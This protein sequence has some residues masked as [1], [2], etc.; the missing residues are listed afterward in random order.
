M[1]KDK[2]GFIKQ[3]IIYILL[4]LFVL[5]IYL[6]ESLTGDSL[7]SLLAS[8]TPSPSP[9]PVPTTEP[10]PIIGIAEDAFLSR[11]EETAFRISAASE[12]DRYSLR[13]PD[14]PDRILLTLSRV[15]GR[16]TA[17]TMDFP[18]PEEPLA[19]T[20]YSSFHNALIE[21]HTFEE[22]EA[23][24]SALER[25]VSLLSDLLGA[26]KI[27]ADVRIR[28]FDGA[29]AAMLEG[30]DYQNRDAGF[31]FRAAPAQSSSGREILRISIAID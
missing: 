24:R 29:Y 18:L 10:T 6:V 21:G 17:L 9:T 31:V 28:W 22:T 19:Q 7:S 13:D 23:A 20:R 27:P 15:Q 16:I 8:A 11:L 3:N 5:G 14:H 30:N 4:I 25:A 1:K 2:S 26:D 12:P